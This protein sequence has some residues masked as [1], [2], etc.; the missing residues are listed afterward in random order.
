[1]RPPLKRHHL[2]ARLRAN[3]ERQSFPRLQMLLL[4]SLTGAAGFIAS[5]TMLRLG[6]TQMGLRYLAAFGFAYL[7]FLGLLWLWLRTKAA[8]YADIADFSNIPLPDG[9]T[10]SGGFS[11]G[12]GSGAG[13]GA[14]GS[15]DSPL[16]GMHADVSSASDSASEALGSV[17]DAVSGADVFALPLVMIVFVGVLLLSSFW[18]VYSA[19]VLFAELLVDGVL[20]ASLY[21]RLRGLESQHWLETAIKKTAWPFLM[22]GLLISALGWGMQ[23]YAPEAHSIGEVVAHTKTASRN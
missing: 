1:M 13:G 22:M 7:A 4:V 15:F 19:P 23:S 11:G 9:G 16:A 3:L 14:S 21:R 8:D 6:L 18:I 17:G 10:P 12:G 5:F 20:A 2:V